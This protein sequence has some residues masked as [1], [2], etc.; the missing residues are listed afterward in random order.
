MVISWP[1]PF[2]FAYFPSA[3]LSFPALVIPNVYLLVEAHFSQDSAGD[4]SIFP[5]FS[6][7]IAD[8]ILSTQVI[9]GLG[10]CS[11]FRQS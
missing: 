4:R 6:R 10:F 9:K 5:L 11:A 3:V 8:H 2:S 7:S 1:E